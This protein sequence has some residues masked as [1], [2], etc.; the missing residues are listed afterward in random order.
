MGE[1]LCTF[2]GDG[3]SCSFDVAFEHL[4]ERALPCGSVASAGRCAV[5]RR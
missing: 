3:A 1:L 5:E 2:D 4:A